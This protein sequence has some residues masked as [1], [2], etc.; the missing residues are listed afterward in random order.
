MTVSPK[1]VEVLTAIIELADAGLIE[2]GGTD[3]IVDQG[4]GEGSLETYSLPVVTYAGRQFIE[5][6]T[7]T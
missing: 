3:M 7:K 5:Q 1:A 6:E 4:Y 2:I